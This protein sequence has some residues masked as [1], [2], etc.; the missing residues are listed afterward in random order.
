MLYATIPSLIRFC[1]FTFYVFS[2]FFSS[3]DLIRLFAFCN[4]AIKEE[5]ITLQCR[6][7][8]R[9]VPGTGIRP[10]KKQKRNKDETQMTARKE[11]KEMK[12]KARLAPIVYAARIS[13]A[14]KTV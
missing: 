9:K 14:K 4:G 8:P 1:F 12:L 7:L 11:R 5:I 6:L 2:T 3:L 10:K 13:G